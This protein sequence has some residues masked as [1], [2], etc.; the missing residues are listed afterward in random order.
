MTLKLS[1]QTRNLF[2]NTK[3]VQ[4]QFVF[5]LFAISGYVYII[6][7]SDINF[8]DGYVLR[9]IS[10]CW[11]GNDSE[12][13]KTARLDLGC[14]ATDQLCLGNKYWSSVN[15]QAITLAILLGVLRLIPS[16]IGIVTG[17]RKFRFATGFEVVWY[18]VMALIVFLGGCI[19]IFYY[20]LRNMPIPLELP[21]L[22]GVGF[23]VYTKSFTGSPLMVEN[24]DLLL[25][26]GISTGLLIILFFVAMFVY[27]KSGLTKDMA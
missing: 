13:C 5:A 15:Y 2:K 17:R 18:P 7:S 24:T 1:K 3:V 27:S 10:E 9:T 21:W 8:F 12:F 14:P 25:T 11:P 26:F 4:F 16:L 23:F 19:D 20:W 22:N 6:G